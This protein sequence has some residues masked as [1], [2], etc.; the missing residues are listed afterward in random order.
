MRIQDPNATVTKDVSGPGVNDFNATGNT[1]GMSLDFGSGTGVSRMFVSLI[2]NTVANMSWCVGTN[3]PAYK[4]RYRWVAQALALQFTSAVLSLDANMLNTVLPGGHGMVDLTKYSIYQ[5]ALDGIGQFCKLPTTYANGMLS[6]NISSL[7]EFFVGSETDSFDHTLSVKD[8]PAVSRLTA[9]PNP[10]DLSA[11]I[12]F[13]LPEDAFTNASLYDMTGREVLKLQEGKM[14]AGNRKLVVNTEGL[15]SGMY[16]CKITAGG[17][18]SAVKV[19][20]GH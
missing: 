5:R 8:F 4:S 2:Y 15:S 11:T 12:S 17:R 16:F 10:A 20:V 1:T 7:S 13:D 14:A 19:T 18:M 6:A 9:Y 3:N